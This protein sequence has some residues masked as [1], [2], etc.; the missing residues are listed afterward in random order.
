MLFECTVYDSPRLAQFHSGLEVYTASD[1]L[2]PLL[3][4]S[5]KSKSTSVR[6][7]AFADGIGADQTAWEYLEEEVK[8][9]DG[10]LAPRPSL[11]LW[12]L[13]MVGGGHTF[14]S[15]IYNGSSNPYVKR[16][17]NSAE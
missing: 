15:G 8:G 5:V 9:P 7:T 3:L 14:A 16:L 17:Q 1:K 4:D 11:E 10:V 13:A 6:V 12:S 2:L